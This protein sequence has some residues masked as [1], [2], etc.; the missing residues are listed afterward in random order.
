MWYLQAIFVYTLVQ[1]QPLKYNDYTYPLWAQAIA[2]CLA[3]C[4]IQWIPCY[5]I[6]QLFTTKGTLYEVSSN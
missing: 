2:W 1:Y 5:A 6:Y 3:L 4:A